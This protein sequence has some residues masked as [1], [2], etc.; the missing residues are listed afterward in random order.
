[1]IEV[2]CDR[3]K[4]RD[5]NEP[6]TMLDEW[7]GRDRHRQGGRDVRSTVGECLESLMFGSFEVIA[8]TVEEQC[9]DSKTQRYDQSTAFMDLTPRCSLLVKS[10]W[11][12]DSRVSHP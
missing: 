2:N 12:S 6:A 10:S 8:G 5:S 3:A 9:R 1:M 7:C 11:L 4:S